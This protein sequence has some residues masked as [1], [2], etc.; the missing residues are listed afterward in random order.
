MKSQPKPRFERARIMKQRGVVLFFALIALLAI[1]L[2]AVALIRS[3]D[4]STMI[5]GNLAF[6]QTATTSADAGLENAIAWLNTTQTANSANNVYT[7]LPAVHAFNVTNAAAAVKTAEIY[8]IDEEKT[9]KILENIE[10]LPGR[11]ELIDEGQNFKVIVDYAHT[12]DSMEAVYKSLKPKLSANFFLLLLIFPN[13]F[14]NQK[15]FLIRIKST[16]HFRLK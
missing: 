12:P 10:S 9:G 14:S 8:G 13:Y 5:A 1:S 3:V 16:L 11:M 6:K 15:V 2:A 7:N 4:T